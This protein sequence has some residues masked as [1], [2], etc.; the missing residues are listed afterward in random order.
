MTLG[1]VIKSF[2]CYYT[3]TAASLSNDGYVPSLDPSLPGQNGCHFADD[4]FKCI[5]MNEKFCILIGISL[6]FV[7]KGPFDNKSAL[8][9]VMAWRRTGGKPLPEPMLTQF[10]DA[11]M[12]H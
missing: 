2:N 11:Y 6:K 10:T 1:T 4:I 3:N 5:F 8:V 7:L 9:E 12:Q